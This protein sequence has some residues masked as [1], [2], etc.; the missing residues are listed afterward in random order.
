MEGYV[1][2]QDVPPSAFLL[3]NDAKVER[4]AHPVGRHVESLSAEC[5]ADSL[6]IFLVTGALWAFLE[7]C[8]TDKYG[9]YFLFSV[10]SGLAVQT[11]PEALVLVAVQCAIGMLLIRKIPLGPRVWLRSKRL[12]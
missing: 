8:R 5:L 10:C 6:F 4:S 7:A 2:H 3:V 9:L 1:V 11:K 12:R